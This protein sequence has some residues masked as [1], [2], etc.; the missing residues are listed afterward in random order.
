[1]PAWPRDETETVARGFGGADA[2]ARGRRA[3]FQI[4]R[5][6]QQE[7]R[8][9]CLHG[10]KLQ[11]L[12]Q[13]QIEPVDHSGDGGRRRRTQ[14]LLQGPES[15]FAVR[16][17]DQDEAGRIEPEGAN[18][19][20]VK[21]AVFAPTIGR[22]D[23]DERRGGRQ[24][25]CRRRGTPMTKF[26]PLALFSRKRETGMRKERHDEAESGGSGA[27]VGHDFMQGA[28]GQTALRQVGIDGRQAERQGGANVLYSRHQAAEFFH[29]DG[30]AAGRGNGRRLGHWLCGTGWY[31]LYVL[32]LQILEQNE[33]YAKWFRNRRA[34]N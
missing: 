10:G 20:T 32:G 21:T 27:L 15:V 25:D 31:S 34:V 9:A 28:T 26:S 14:R 4:L 13:F 5:R 29:N 6:P 22:H 16:R 33:N 23:E 11:P 12:A 30:A 18:A 24:S 1:M 7:E 8:Q 17:L 3:R 19:M 2:P